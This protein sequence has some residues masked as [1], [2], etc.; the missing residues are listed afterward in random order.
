M[1]SVLPI[2]LRCLFA[3]ILYFEYQG[4]QQCGYIKKKI[5]IE[6]YTS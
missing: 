4:K 1:S 5:A 3:Q 2:L 6:V